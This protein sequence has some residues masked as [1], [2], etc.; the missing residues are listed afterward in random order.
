MLMHVLDFI[1]LFNRVQ[2]DKIWLTM[3]LKILNFFRMVALKSRLGNNY[4]KYKMNM[5]IHIYIIFFAV[6]RNLYLNYYCNQ[7]NNNLYCM[8]SNNIFLYYSTFGLLLLA[9][10][11][12]NNIP[13]YFQNFQYILTAMNGDI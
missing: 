4:I 9:I 5:N 6:L 3:I 1:V 8:G 11:L 7:Y 10:I 13:I 2:N 12:N